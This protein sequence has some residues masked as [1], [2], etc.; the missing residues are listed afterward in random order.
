LEQEQLMR[1]NFQEMAAEAPCTACSWTTNR[2]DT[3][4]YHS[5]VKLFYSISDRAAWSLGPK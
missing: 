3:G 4:R 2:Q 1:K 5:S